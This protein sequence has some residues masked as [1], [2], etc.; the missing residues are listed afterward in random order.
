ME[1]FQYPF[2]QMGSYGFPKLSVAFAED[3]S[4]RGVHTKGRGFNLIR[5]ERVCKKK[6]I[7]GLGLI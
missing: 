4:W 6:R 5:W 1:T 2:L 7:W 3:F